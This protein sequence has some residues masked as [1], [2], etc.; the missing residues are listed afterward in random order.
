[1][2]QKIIKAVIFDMDGVIS[3]TEV[4]HTGIDSMILAD[5]GIDLMPQIL[6]ARY[7]GMDAKIK[8]EKI[9]RDYK[10]TNINVDELVKKK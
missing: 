2:P 10:K 5:H 1:M 6:S 3:D 4:I 8:F 7:S 9:F